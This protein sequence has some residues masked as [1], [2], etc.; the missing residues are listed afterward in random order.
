M[1]TSRN[2]SRVQ[3]PFYLYDESPGNGVNRIVCEGLSGSD[4]TA[5]FYRRK[6]PYQRQ[7]DAVCC[8][9]YKDCGLYQALMKKYGEG[10]KT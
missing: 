9:R 6:K 2:D 7:I 4:T 1:P 8:A 3:C 10:E 5:Q